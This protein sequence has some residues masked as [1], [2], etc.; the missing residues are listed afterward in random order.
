MPAKDWHGSDSWARGL[1]IG[2][3]SDWRLPTISELKGIFD[4]GTNTQETGGPVKYS[5]VFSS[6]GTDLYWSSE[7]PSFDK[8]TKVGMSYGGTYESTKSDCLGG[9]RAVR[10]GGGSPGASGDGP[11][12]D[13]RF[14]D[15]GDGTVTDSRTGLMW[16][17][18]DTWN[19]TKKCAD[20]NYSNSWAQGLRLGGYSDWRLPTIS[21]LK[22][23]FDS[24]TNTQETGGPVKYSPVFSSRGTDLYWSSEGPSFDKRTKVGMSFGGTYESTKS[25]CLGG[26]RAVRSS[27]GA[28][29]FQGGGGGASDGRFTDLGNGAVKDSRTGLM[30]TKK[31]TWNVFGKCAD[32]HASNDWAEGLNIGGYTD[33]RLPTENEL[34]GIFKSGV[35]TQATGGNVNYTRIFEK[36]GTDLYWTDGGG[37]LSQAK[38]V[39]M[40]FGSTYDSSKTECIGGARAVRGP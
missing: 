28:G 29:N 10:S 18:N 33:W 16:S 32:W 14:T 27:R 35:N 22:G 31:D 7:G 13:G 40:S 30:W 5:P 39:G 6:R 8:R 23:I 26:A 24:G 15:N 38:Q 2:G 4:S 19:L 20:W 21:E 36:G 34:K 12:S 9:A 37:T 3:Y 1:R 25:D 17:K 11:K